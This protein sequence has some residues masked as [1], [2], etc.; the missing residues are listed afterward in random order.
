MKINDNALVVTGAGNGMGREVALGLMAKGA[1]IAA[2]DVNAAGLEETL[3]LADAARSAS[4]HVLDVTDRAAVEE[5]VGEVV[6]IHGH[7]DGLVN[8]AGIIHRFVSVEDLSAAEMTRVMNVNF[9][10][11]VNTSLA[12]LPVLKQRPEATLTN[13]SSL[14]ALIPFAGQTLYGAS[15]GGVKQFSEGLYQELLG[16]SVHVS[17]IFPG[18][19]STNI[20]GNSG[21]QMID[22]GGRKVRATNPRNAA[23]TIVE[24][25]ERNRFRILVGSDALLLDRLVRFAP[26][27]TTGMIARQMKSVM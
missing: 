3:R 26:R 21:V 6:D 24:G 17:T 20:S 23:A 13:M 14:S 19:I 9:W 2:V 18:N 25:I 10:G 11:T 7:V 1:R 4:A 8:I 27:W 5:L 22:A 12:F 16:T 15:K